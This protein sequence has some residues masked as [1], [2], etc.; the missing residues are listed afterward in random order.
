MS[1]LEVCVSNRVNISGKTQSLQGHSKVMYSLI[2]FTP[3]AQGFIDEILN[4]LYFICTFCFVLLF[5]FFQDRVSLCSPGSPGTHSVDQTGLE[6][7]N[8]PTS[9]S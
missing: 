9:S 7:R 4:C 2:V 8:P 6:L 1:L 5:L 3:S